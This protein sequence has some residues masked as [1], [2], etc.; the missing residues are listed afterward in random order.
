MDPL[1]VWGCC[2]C[3]CT[4]CNSNLVATLFHI[5]NMFSVCLRVTDTHYIRI[6]LIVHKNYNK[7]KQLTI[8][9]Q[10][11]KWNTVKNAQ[12]LSNPLPPLLSYLTA[13]I[14]GTFEAVSLPLLHAKRR[15]SFFGLC[16][17]IKNVLNTEIFVKK[18]D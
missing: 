4:C 3:I 15:N 6:V 10:I 17:A 16:L 11:I 7:K 5:S 18:L 2:D 8:S 12:K 14:F 13:L 1:E 9:Q